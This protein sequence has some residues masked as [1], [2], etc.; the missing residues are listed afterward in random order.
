LLPGD[1]VEVSA[2]EAE[3]ADK[4]LEATVRWRYVEGF[5]PAKMPEAV[6]V[7]VGDEKVWMAPARRWFC[8]EGTKDT[9]RYTHGGLSLAELA[10]P[11]AV[12]RRVTEK[13]ARVELMDL[14]VV[15][16][17]DEDAIVDLPVTVRNSGNCD[18]EFELRVVNNLGEEILSQR[19]WL[20]PANKVKHTARVLARYKETSSR[21]PDMNNTVTAVTLR[22]R[23]TD[24]NGQWRDA[25][26]GLITI[27]VKVKP[28]A[29]KL[30]TDALKGFD[31]I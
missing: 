8:R 22:L 19:N 14:P 7:S 4:K 10:V 30:E 20:A 13:E 21:E 31:E 29:V 11:G 23:H 12:L 17:A 9:P 27:P 18:V 1:A 15:I 2:T 26:D 24:L 28:K 3:Q 6:A 5:A 16:P 25:I